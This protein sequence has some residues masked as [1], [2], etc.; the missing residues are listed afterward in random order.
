MTICIGITQSEVQCKRVVK[1]GDYCCN[2]VFQFNEFYQQV[3]GWP[4]MS[5][6]NKEINEIIKKSTN[7]DILLKE[8]KYYTSC[9]IDNDRNTYWRKK[10]FLIC[11]KVMLIKRNIV[12]SNNSFQELVN[13]LVENYRELGSNDVLD[14]Y[15]L[16]FRRKVDESYRKEARMKN[17]IHFCISHSELGQDIA[18]IIC[19]FLYKEVIPFIN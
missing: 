19:G 13:K 8:V 17:Y 15:K 9:F 7:D 5:E 4:G 18:D 11:T 10:C 16:N 2:H 6:V 12:L 1:N 3:D 14:V